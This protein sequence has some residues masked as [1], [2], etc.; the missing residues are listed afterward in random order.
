MTN[1][2]A[3]VAIRARKATLC[4]TGGSLE[5]KEKAILPNGGHSTRG[6]VALKWRI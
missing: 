1:I 2:V 6:I 3:I 5:H 4:S